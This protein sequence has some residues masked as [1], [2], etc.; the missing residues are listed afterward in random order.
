MK[1]KFSFEYVPN[2]ADASTGFDLGFPPGA[3]IELPKVGQLPGIIGI[4]VVT[5][6]DG[7]VRLE[8]RR[9]V[10]YLQVHLAAFVPPSVAVRIVDGG[11]RCTLARW[12]SMAPAATRRKCFFRSKDLKLPAEKCIEVEQL[13]RTTGFWRLA[14]HEQTNGKDGAEWIV[15]RRGHLVQLSRGGRRSPARYARSARNSWISRAGSIQPMK[16]LNRIRRVKTA[17]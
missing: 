13:M 12:N 6:S 1:D 7:R 11:G 9:Q 16:L 5:R 17:L 2:A 4:P 15:E 10:E 3:Q 8:G 14:P